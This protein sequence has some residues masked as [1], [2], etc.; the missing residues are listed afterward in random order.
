MQD[1][2]FWKS[3]TIWAGLIVAAVGIIRAIGYGDFVPTE[4][5]ISLAGALGIV[6]IRQAVS[7]K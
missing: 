2:P 6:G 5:V 1:K 3:K 7:K 4:L